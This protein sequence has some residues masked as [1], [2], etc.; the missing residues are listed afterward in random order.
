MKVV[1]GLPGNYTL[2]FQSGSAKSDRSLTFE[3]A[4]RIKEINITK[5]VETNVYKS[6][7]TEFIKFA[8]QP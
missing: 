4:N 7:D 6:D 3:L 1:T 8:T 5:Q 2:T